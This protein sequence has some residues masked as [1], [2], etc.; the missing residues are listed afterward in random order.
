MD[1]DLMLF[2]IHPYI[3]SE[4]TGIIQVGAHLG[5][6]Y[7]SLSK[8]STNILMFEPQTNIYNQLVEKLGSKEG[9]IIENLALGSERKT[10]VMFKEQANGGQS[11]S[12]LLPALHLVQY[13]VIE[14]NDSE[15]V[16]VITLDEYF[17]TTTS[18]YNLMTL[19]VQGYELEVLKG[20]KKTLEKVQYILCEVNRAEL[21]KDCPMVEQIDEFLKQFG[22]ERIVTS[23]DGQTWGDALYKKK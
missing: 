11:S 16:N 6:E 3:D 8:L 13:P 19:D 18:N 21:Y 5:N 7:D 17:E 1:G 15:E 2:D 10:A 20:A 12:L 4:I 9:V 22:F 14:F 23:W